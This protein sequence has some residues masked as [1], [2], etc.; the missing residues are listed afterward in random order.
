MP[1]TII[2]LLSALVLLV[3]CFSFATPVFAKAPP[4]LAHSSL[5][6][7]SAVPADGQTKVTV[8]VILKDTSGNPVVE[9][10]VTLKDPNDGSAVIIPTSTTTD[11]AGR[12]TFTITSLYPGTYSLDIIDTTT[13]TPFNGLGTVVFNPTSGVQST[14]TNPSPGSTP[15]LTSA[16]TIGNTQIM[17]TWTKSLDPVS[18][19]LV[20]YGVSSG[21]YQYGNPRIGGRDT[22]A[23]TI[24]S[25]SPNTKYYFI[26]KAVNG[27]MP[28]N[29]SNELSATTLTKI[30]TITVSTPT[31]TIAFQLSPTIASTVSAAPTQV[32]TLVLPTAIPAKSKPLVKS[33][34]ETKIRIIAIGAII[35]LAILG[36]AFYRHFR[37][38]KKSSLG[39]FDKEHP[40]I[41]PESDTGEDD[42]LL[43]KLKQ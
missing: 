6:V 10:T 11:G 4:D 21:Q 40:L 1:K 20:A 15:Q 22:T 35:I 43:K 5:S 42:S 14:C 33:L 16:K 27:C 24:D 28:G 13:N 37:I 34:N 39:I 12:A 29:N 3:L 38:R 36:L 18:H 23:F 8:T 32:S 2:N 17:L 26:I 19:Y 41:F 25:L 31:P 30:K 9:D 7:S